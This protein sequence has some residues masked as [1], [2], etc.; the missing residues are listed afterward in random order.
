MIESGGNSWKVVLTVESV[1]S[2]RAIIS[3]CGSC[4]YLKRFRIHYVSQHDR[5][6]FVQLGELSCNLGCET[7]VDRL[8]TSV[9]LHVRPG[10]ILHS[11]IRKPGKYSVYK[12]A[13]ILLTLPSEQFLFPNGNNGT[14]MVPAPVQL[15]LSVF[16]LHILP[17]LS[18]ACLQSNCVSKRIT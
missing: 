5:F 9:A 14:Y 8:F 1:D 18:V 2:S 7:T 13:K 3:S 10:R 4:K 12:V 15:L 6:D 11:Y 17:N 16:L